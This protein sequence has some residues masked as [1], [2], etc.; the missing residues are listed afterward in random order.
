[1]GLSVT[2]FLWW[3]SSINIYDALNQPHT[4]HCDSNHPSFLISPSRSI[5]ISISSV[6]WSHAVGWTSPCSR[7]QRQR[8]KAR[9]GK[10]EEQIAADTKLNLKWNVCHQTTEVERNWRLVREWKTIRSSVGMFEMS[11]E[12]LLTITNY[13]SVK[14]SH[15]KAQEASMWSLHKSTWVGICMSLLSIW[16]VTFSGIRGRLWRLHLFSTTVLVPFHKPL[17]ELSSF[18]LLQKTN[19]SAYLAIQRERRRLFLQIEII[20]RRG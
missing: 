3:A 14:Q 12:L 13:S 8:E 20:R 6:W 10:G 18:C 7:R 17:C 5:L 11:K 4:E 9:D 16:E 19:Q 2:F 1:M 15:G